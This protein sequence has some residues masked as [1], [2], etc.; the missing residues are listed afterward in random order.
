M[1]STEASHAPS[2]HPSNSTLFQPLRVGAL[3]LSHRLIMAPLTRFRS[4]REYVPNSS[5]MA[6]YY[7]QRACVP[8]TLL[9]TEATVI[10]LS[11]AGYLNVPG[12]WS[13]EQ[14]AAWKPVTEA[15]HAKGSYIFC[16]LWA[17]GRVAIPGNMREAG[18]DVV[19]S[20]ESPLEPTERTPNPDKPRALAEVEVQEFIAQY[21]Q[22]ARNA[23]EAGFDG[24]EVHGANGYLVDQFTQD[25]VNKRTDRWGG[26][27]ENRSRFGA[28]VIKACGEAIGIE[29][30][31]IRLSPWSTFQGMKM[32]DPIPQFTDLVSKL[33]DLGTSYLHLVESRIAG[34]ADVEAKV[35]ERVEFAVTEFQKEAKFGRP[36]FVAG[37]F[38]PDSARR[39]A[40][41][42]HGGREVGI[43]FGRLWIANPDLAFR[44]KEGID[45]T[46]YNRDT[47]YKVESPE[48]YVDY[49]YS[50]E[51]QQ[52]AGPEARL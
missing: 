28:E 22:A 44:I 14:I 45:L 34:N 3:Q 38:K 32:T 6:E 13:K 5:L 8:G 12:I 46:P 16:Q 15:V 25:V 35:G 48:G 52:S 9:I 2:D 7:A 30:V 1:S 40:D 26:S 27:I 47:F 23:R 4:T 50:K 43:V 19:S 49:P 17:L 42:E 11:A 41:V 36:V 33:R 31:G 18:F 21:A 39:C 51:W 24:V 20:S 29:R 10:S 37:G